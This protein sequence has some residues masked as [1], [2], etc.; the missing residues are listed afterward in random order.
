[1]AESQQTF[2]FRV[3]LNFDIDLRSLVAEDVVTFILTRTSRGLDKNNKP[4]KRYSKSY[5]N[6]IDFKIAGKSKNQVNLELSGDMLTDLEILNIQTAGFI[7]IGFIEGTE[8]NDRAAWNRN[9]LRPSHPKRDFLG[10]NDSDLNKIIN[11]YRNQADE[12]IR[13]EKQIRNRIQEEA[14]KLLAGFSLG[15]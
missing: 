12:K 7:T 9:N 11:K 3:P 8:E 5:V 15:N 14:S 1:M 4:F 10:I 2:T 6:S 13:R